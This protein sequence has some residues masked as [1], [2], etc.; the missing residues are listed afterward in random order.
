MFIIR[1]N[2]PGLP[3]QADHQDPEHEVKQAEGQERQ[4]E[5]A[6]PAAVRGS[7]HWAPLLRIS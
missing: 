5:A 7:P 3:H 1:Q 4:A 6:P 2:S